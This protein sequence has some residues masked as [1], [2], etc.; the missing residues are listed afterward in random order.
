MSPVLLAIISV[1]AIGLICAVVLAVASHFMGVPVNE[2]EVFQVSRLMVKF[3]VLNA[4]PAPTAA[5]AALPAVT[6]MQ[7]RLPRRKA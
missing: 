7:R 2:K 6:V 4:S 5:H 3:G 1:T